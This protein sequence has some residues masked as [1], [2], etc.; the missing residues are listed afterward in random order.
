MKKILFI[1][2]IILLIVGIV[3]G[4]SFNMKIKEEQNSSINKEFESFLNV[5]IRG[6]SLLSLMNRVI[7]LNDK[8]G[9][10][11]DAEGL[12]IEN[13]SNSMKIYIKF[14]DRENL[15]SFE[16]IDDSGMEKFAQNF[17]A[18]LFRCNKIE[19]HESTGLIS[20]MYFQEVD[21]ANVGN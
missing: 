2:C 18:I 8:N 3:L 17:A 15:F 16:K 6:S 12:Y 13:D 7:D 10:E 5:D 19:Y 11:K 20:K 14:I 4:Y 1:I 21:E 9:I